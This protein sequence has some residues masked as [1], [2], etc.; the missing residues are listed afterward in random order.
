MRKRIS[1]PVALHGD[2]RVVEKSPGTWVGGTRGPG[3]IPGLGFSVCRE[4]QDKSGTF[5]PR[6][7]EGPF[8]GALQ[9]NISGTAASYRK[10]ASYFAALAELRAPTRAEYHEHLEPL[11][12]ADG[13]TRLHIVIRRR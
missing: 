12:S 6:Q 8:K 11:E 7:S 2:G 10:L 5:N 1:L 13:A 3:K 9:V 4:R